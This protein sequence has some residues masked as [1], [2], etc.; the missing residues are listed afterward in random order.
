MVFSGTPFLFVFLPI[1][2][3]GL[4]VLRSTS[5]RNTWL[6]VA[7]L[8][9]YIWGEQ[10]RIVVLLLSVA[11]CAL[12]GRVIEQAAAPRRRAGLALGIGVQLGLLG[13]YKYANFA[14]EN[15]NAV[16]AA[17]GLL[18]VA[19]NEIALPIGISFFTFQAITYLVDIARGVVP[20]QRCVSRVAL[21]I[22]LFPQL[23]AGP[24]VRY[25]EIAGQLTQRQI[26]VEGAALGVRRFIV[27]LAKK[28]LL[29]NSLAVP[30]DAIFSLPADELRTGV[31]LLGV[32]AYG[33]Q[34]YFDFSGYSDMAIGLGRILGFR[35][36]ENFAYPYA[37]A[38][39][40][41]FWRRWHMTLS[42]FFR[43]YLY[44]P[45]G[46]NRRGR[47]RT[48]LHLLAV[49]VLCGIWHGASWNFVL[50]GLGHGV[51]LSLERTAFGRRLD[52]MPRFIQ[53][54]YVI[55]L[56]GGAW[57]LFRAD[58]LPA[59]TAFFSALAGFGA[60]AGPGVEAFLTRDVGVTFFVGVLASLPIVPALK[61]RWG[62][63]VL[64]AT[65][66]GVRYAGAAAALIQ[67]VSLQALFWLCVM[68]LLAGSHNP[69]IYFRF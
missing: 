62:E 8:L 54:A 29:A 9:F 26:S 1:V 28:V 37:A 31:A 63:G 52:R 14:V 40:R 33:L 61:R 21:Y 55:S 30:A 68:T 7:S 36:P 50:W 46:G 5:A 66:A 38:S 20:A 3:I 43:D 64:A 16:R 41:E 24:I 57:V 67:L 4:F 23:I 22:A 12:L 60:S 15:V 45:L 44:V 19:W 11:V 25:S 53:H 6:L 13:Y 51:F 65:T 69:F 10:E 17:T 42:R 59:A 35:F 49:F 39:M 27:G 47:L 58:D 32:V 34:I 18:P 2:L 56:V 48:V